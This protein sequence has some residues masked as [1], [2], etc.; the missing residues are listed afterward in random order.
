MT[1]FHERHAAGAHPSLRGQVET[2]T[3]IVGGGLAGL[4]A[5]LSLIEHGNRSLVLLE[6]HEL[7]SGASGR[8]AGLVSPGFELTAWDVDELVGREQSQRLFALSWDAVRQLRA[9]I[10]R[11]AI[12]CNVADCGLIKPWWTPDLDEARRQ[13]DF[14]A[15]VLHMRLELW[16]SEQTRRVLK[17]TRYH[18]AL[19]SSDAFALSPLLYACGVAQAVEAGGGRIHEHS[20]VIGI[21]NERAGILVKTAQGAVRARR[22]LIAGGAYLRGIVPE[23]ERAILPLLTHVMITAPF[24]ERLPDA[25]CSTAGIFDSRFD[26]DYYRV[27]PDGRIVF[28]GG[29]SIRED[30]P[31]RVMKRLRKR[32]I[33]IYPQLADV[34]RIEACWSGRMAYPRH[35]MP[36]LAE[37]RPDIWYSAGHAGHGLGTTTL[38]GELFARAVL[39]GDDTY[40]ALAPFRLQWAGGRAGLIAAKLTFAYYKS[41]DL[42]SDFFSSSKAIA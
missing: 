16:P 12:A 2:E 11:Y 17:T 8:S 27:I 5:A 29:M 40:R 42:V 13:R 15:E 23:L 10:D 9:R 1:F 32:F 21:E 35:Q 33:S 4:C 26:H 38:L 36:M 39:R 19:Y 28:G 22:V 20:A 30:P 41:L 18:H 34:L 25:I 3:C 14:A 31:E 37:L 24:G 7:G 6:A